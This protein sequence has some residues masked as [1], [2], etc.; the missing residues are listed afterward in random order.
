MIKLRHIL[1]LTLVVAFLPVA[2]QAHEKPEEPALEIQSLSPEGQFEYEKDE[3]AIATNKVLVKYGSAILTADRASINVRTGEVEADGQ[4][5]LQR[6]DAIW[7]GEHVRY[8]FKTRKLETEQFRTGKTPIFAAGEGLRCDV[9]NQVYTAH[10]SYATTDDVSKPFTKVRANYIKFVRGKYVEARNAVLYVGGV[11]AFYFPYYRRNLGDRANHW[12]FTPGYRSSY[13]PYLLSTYEWFLGEQ[14]DGAL[15]FDYR[16]KRGFGAGPDANL[17]LDRW[18]ELGL[19]YYYMYDNDPGES[20]EGASIPH[21]RQRFHLDY[22]ATPFTNLNVKAQVN[23][24]SD[25]DLLHDFFDSEYRRDPQ[26]PTF[27][28]VNRLW[29]N[30][31]LDTFVQP[32]VNDFYETVERLPELKLTGF[33]QQIGTL[34]FYYQ[35]DSSAGWYQREFAEQTNSYPKTNNFSAAR[36][37]TFHQILM[38]NTFFGWLNFTPRVGGRL[39]YYGQ[40]YGPGAMTDEEYRAVFNTGAELN[41]KASRLWA[42]ATNRWL[43]LDGL[44]HIVEPS[45]NYVYIPAPNNRPPDLPQFDYESASFRLLPIDFPDYND[46]DSINS[47]NVMRFGL[48]NKLQTKRDGRV[49]NLVNWDVYSDW[50]LNPNS[51]QNTFS[52]VYS[53]LLLRPRSWISLESQTGYNIEDGQFDQSFHT[54]TLR[55]NDVWQWSVSHFYLRNNYSSSPDAWGIGNNVISS[56]I[57]YRLNE[58]WAVRSTQHFEARNGRMEE[59]FYTL[60][61]DFRSWTGALTFRV[62]EQDNGSEDYTVA[63]TF[64]L[65][66]RPRFGLG[67]DA[68]KQE[69]LLGN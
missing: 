52:D 28:E 38:P 26:P 47:Q 61:R 32:R 30:F 1:L 69:Q 36:A 49:E 24:Q 9:S 16:A 40:A 25:E 27:V 57:F 62:R 64:S 67:T 58:N 34:P 15:H 4:V 14:M 13:G 63:F 22:D 42:G 8:N 18:G 12:N 23:Y 60:Y 17:H 11:P 55:P 44:R 65:K 43:E 3:V 20:N 39:T 50:R 41:F 51:E 7:A 6:D 21:N 46:I 33:R 37:D 19:K 56:T 5:R 68:V 29:D 2:V 53:D 59:Q 31:S 48:R 66:A 10:K 35:S 54:L 45:L